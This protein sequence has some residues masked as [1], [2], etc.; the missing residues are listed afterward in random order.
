MNSRL[1][2]ATGAEIA[3][4]SAS[5]RMIEPAC[6]FPKAAVKWL[7]I[8]RAHFNIYDSHQITPPRQINVPI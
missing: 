1:N 5:W 2:D 7:L 3:S 6:C 4:V 8:G